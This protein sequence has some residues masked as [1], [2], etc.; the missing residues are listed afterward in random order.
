M[1]RVLILGLLASVGGVAH[2]AD[3]PLYQAPPAWVKPAP[4]IDATK[5]SDD[6]PLLLTFDRQERLADGTVWSYSDVATR[7]ATPQ[8]VAE[9]GTLNIPWQPSAGDLIIHKVEIIR[10]AEHIDLLAAGKRFEV[11]RREQGLEQ[12]QVNGRLTATMA[13]EGLHVGDVL[14]LVASVTDKEPALGG[15]MQADA[16]LPQGQG[17]LG[18]VRARLLWPKDADVRWRGYADGLHPAEAVVGGDREL[19][20]TGALPKAAELPDDAPLRFRKLPLIEA[21]TFKDWA[22]VAR[23]MAPLYATEGV[24]KPG[25]A[26][27][28]EVKAIGAAS[29]DPLKRTA[30]A[31]QLV[32]EKVRYLYNGLGSGNYVPQTP[33]QTW[34]LRYGDCKAKTLLLLAVLHE[35]GIAGE[36]VLA[37]GTLGDLLPQ[38]LPSAAAFDHILVHADVAG[39]SLWLDGTGSAS[40]YSGLR[41]TPPFRWVL[42]ATTTATALVAVP[43]RAPAQPGISVALD[44]DQSAG[45]GLPTLVHAVVTMRGPAAE[46]VGLAKSQGTKDQKDAMV[47]GILG[48]L[49]GREVA[50]AGYTLSYDAAEA[51]AVVD[52]SGIASSNWQRSDGRYRLLLDKTVSDLSFEPDRARPA[53]RDIPVAT[54][55]P[56]AMSLRTRVRLPADLAGFTLE[57]DAALADRLAGTTVKRAASI[58]N[59]WVTVDEQASSTGAEIAPADVPA[60]RA[61]VALAKQRLL[62]AV[63]PADLPRRWA[64][65]EAGKRDGRFKPIL[66]TYA[67]AVA[68]DPDKADG[69]TNRANFLLGVF[70]WQAALPDIDRAIALEPTAQRL[71]QRAWVHRVLGN[72]SQDV[73]DVEA[74][75]KLDP[76][77]AGA[78]AALGEDEVDHGKREAALARVQERIDAGGEGK[79]DM[80]VL[81]ANLLTRAGD[82]SAISLLDQTIAAKP[83]NPEL[84]NDRC[85]DKA[86]LDTALDTALKDC[87]KAIELSDSSLAALDSRALVYFRLGRM[88]EALADVD[89]VLEQSPDAASTIFLRGL[90]RARKGDAAGAK[91]DLAAAQAMDPLLA[92]ERK[93]FGIAP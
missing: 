77:S 78:L 72:R 43:M 42:P 6:S 63:A 87:T 79:T 82:L 32:Q 2:A 17:N 16:S 15:N 3:K 48:K 40:R 57:G 56:D 75:R 13:V 8:V 41:D 84:L 54:G 61:R 60:A 14:H 31:L 93:R 5:L 59:G 58:A 53:W 70:D 23:V 69:Y 21:S 28:A 71:L 46:M 62:K 66:A 76:A 52:A 44:L 37:N 91:G 24:I 34:T 49:A 35:L 4:A 68:A 51:L 12:R 39:E 22:A 92:A 65:A 80:I 45:I 9:A 88:D 36:P 19:V 86:L 18:F 20:F 11:L 1:R 55:T 64:A 89:A 38:R 30:A 10:G 67:K 83:G 7:L 25:G 29:S 90:I 73:A 27:A 47:G 85:W 74:A 81:K 50:L 26:L 33:E